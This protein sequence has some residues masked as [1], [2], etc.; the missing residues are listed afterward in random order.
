MKPYAIVAEGPEDTAALR[1]LFRDAGGQV[2]GGGIHDSHRSPLAIRLDGELVQIWSAQGKARLTERTIFAAQ[3]TASYRP[4]I[5]VVCFDP[6]ADDEPGEFAF[7]AS[8]FE[9]VRG[10]RAGPISFEGGVAT[11][12]IGDRAVRL[13][14]AP[15]RHD[16]PASHASLPDEQ[17]L[18][19]LLITGVLRAD[20]SRTLIPWA[21]K[22]TADLLPLVEG[23]GWKRAF[24][25]WNAALEPKSEAF[26]DAL[27]QHD[28]KDHCLAALRESR[29]WKT[30]S[31]LHDA[32]DVPSPIE[33]G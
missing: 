1:G 4:E 10:D 3:G 18:E 17:N 24:R 6:D 8:A 9:A 13:L 5:V 29:A 21:T 23:H 14:P 26:V 7:F 32:R 31:T 27:L 22:A 11:F 15:W 30:I 33:G 20:S 12:R 19:R 25:I 2:E 16:A 28:A